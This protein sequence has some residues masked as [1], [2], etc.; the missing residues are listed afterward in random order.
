MVGD[1]HLV[2]FY[3]TAAVFCNDDTLCILPRGSVRRPSG[4]FPDKLATS[5]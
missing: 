4:V 5:N 1:T 2:T 3:V